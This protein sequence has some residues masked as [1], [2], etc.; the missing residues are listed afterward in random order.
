[1]QTA[2][3][4][5]LDEPL[6]AL[7]ALTCIEMHRLIE[8][9]WQRHGFTAL[10]VTHDVTEAVALADRVRTTALPWT[11]LCRW[12][13]RARVVRLSMRSRIEC[14]GAGR[15][16]GTVGVAALAGERVALGSPKLPGVRPAAPWRDRY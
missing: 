8:R 6:G 3:L 9:L 14:F 1:V 2:R 5:L 4:L 11:N 12:P 13:D 7:D 10:L 15:R 16:G